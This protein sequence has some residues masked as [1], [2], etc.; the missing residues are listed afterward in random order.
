VCRKR[1]IQPTWVEKWG[2]VRGA[3]R[4]GS[5]SGGQSRRIPCLA[6]LQFINKINNY[7]SIIDK[8]HSKL[9]ISVI[10]FILVTTR[11]K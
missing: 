11:N 9:S 4:E 1:A 5:Q 2:T 8:F 6:P 3:G 7:R 10:V